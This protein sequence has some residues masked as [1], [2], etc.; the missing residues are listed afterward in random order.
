[1]E[2]EER[3]SAKKL[4]DRRNG[5]SAPSYACRQK[6]KSESTK[7]AVREKKNYMEREK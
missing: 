5:E 3:G 1:V 6:K 4:T 2:V 7:E